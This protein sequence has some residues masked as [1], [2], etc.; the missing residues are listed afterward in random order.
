MGN[1]NKDRISDHF[2]YIKFEKGTHGVN[3]PK[4]ELS[5]K[6]DSSVSKGLHHVSFEKRHEG[7]NRNKRTTVRY[8][9]S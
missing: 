4:T 2:R 8:S 6:H 9:S 1:P 3:T 7:S 5:M